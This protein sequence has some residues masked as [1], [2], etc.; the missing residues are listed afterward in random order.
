MRQAV[1]RESCRKAK[2]ADTMRAKAKQEHTTFD[3]E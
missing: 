2:S 1:K 3:K